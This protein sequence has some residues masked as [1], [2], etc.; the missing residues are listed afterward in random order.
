MG[1]FLQFVGGLLIF[2]GVVLAAVQANAARLIAPGLA[3]T[4][5]VITVA[6]CVVSGVVMIA[7]GQIYDRV[8]EIWR[9]LPPRGDDAFGPVPDVQPPQPPQPPRPPEEGHALSGDLAGRS[10]LWKRYGPAIDEA[11]KRD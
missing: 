7:L 5:A 8:T 11:A 1:G 2:A 4:S 9:R 10:E 6:S 3:Y